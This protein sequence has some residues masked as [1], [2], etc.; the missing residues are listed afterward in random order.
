MKNRR[1]WIKLDAALL[2]MGKNAAPLFRQ[3]RGQAAPCPAYIQINPR[4]RLV[5]AIIDVT[6]SC[7][8]KLALHRGI[9]VRIPVPPTVK[10]EALLRFCKSHSVQSLMRRICDGWE[11][12]EIRPG[13]IHGAPDEAAADALV[14]LLDRAKRDFKAV[15]VVTDQL[16]LEFSERN[17]AGDLPPCQRGYQEG[18]D[19]GRDM[20]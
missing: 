6:H 7:D 19:Q 3:P 14:E 12:T 20:R 5:E 4:S 1:N 2:R 8:A 15:A 16:P 17:S 11:M 13:E 10:G 9:L 18:T